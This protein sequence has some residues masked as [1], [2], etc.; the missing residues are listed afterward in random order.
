[1]DKQKIIIII[2]ALN[3]EQTI[4]RVI[5]GIKRYADE[6]I[7][8]NDASQDKTAIIAQQEGALVISH[9]K[10]QGYDR[11]IDDG[12]A[13]A[14]ERGATVVLTFD[15]DG[16]HKSEDIARFVEPILNN[17]A[18]VVVGKRPRHARAAEHLF[19]F[20]SK[21][22]ANIDDPLCGLKAYHI[23]VYKDIGYFDRISSIG[24][25]LVFNAKKR[26]YRIIQK[27][28]TLNTRED[29]TRFGRWIKGNWKI[30]KA[31]V[32]T[33]CEE[34]RRDGKDKNKRTMGR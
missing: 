17:E 3:E 28:I 11:S 27:D 9:K 24:T 2:P 10:N 13:L 6:I 25:Q 21:I 33:I 5:N 31:I 18:D 8:V 4:A 20:I 15:G 29:I 32:R 1:M 30:F 34:V 12:F 16:Q 22:K 26:G 23:N 19:A 14:A 7:V